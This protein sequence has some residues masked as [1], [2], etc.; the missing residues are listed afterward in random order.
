MLEVIMRLKQCISGV[1]LDKN[2][3]YAPNIT[4]ITPAQAKDNFRSAVVP[5]GN[6]GGVV[7]LLKRGRAEVDE[8][9]LGVEQY[10]PC[11]TLALCVA[12]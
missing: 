12:A 2:T 6:N 4:R 8:A 10:P 11:S 9:D 1:E 3:P 5:R 7:F